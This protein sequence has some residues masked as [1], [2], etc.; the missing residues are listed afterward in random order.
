M[1]HTGHQREA[2]QRHPFQMSGPGGE[3]ET[4]RTRAG[5]SIAVKTDTAVDQRFQTQPFDQRRRQDG[6]G[7]LHRVRV[8]EE[9]VGTQRVITLPAKCD[10]MRLSELT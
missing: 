2:T 4:L 6:P 3:F 10:E 5:T 8:I 9:R 7:V 1:T